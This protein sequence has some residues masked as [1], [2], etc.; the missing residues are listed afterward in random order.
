MILLRGYSIICNSFQSA[1]SSDFG[2]LPVRGP[3]D[4]RA[5]LYIGYFYSPVFFFVVSLRF[6]RRGF[7]GGTSRANR[8]VP[9]PA[10]V[11]PA[12]GPAAQPGRLSGRL[13][14]R[15]LPL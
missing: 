8:C 6:F 5:V 14:P 2:E 7:A 4:S 1:Y 10:A 15:R 12:A 3:K 9:S 13:I 11:F